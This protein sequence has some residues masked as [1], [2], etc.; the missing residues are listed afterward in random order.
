[1]HRSVWLLSVLGKRRPFPFFPSV[2]IITKKNCLLRDM[3][4]EHQKPFPKPRKHSVSESVEYLQA[5]L[6][7]PNHSLLPECTFR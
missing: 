2:H 7:L 5:F 4:G 6:K 1:M 3:G